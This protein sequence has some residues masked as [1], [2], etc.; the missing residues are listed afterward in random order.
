MRK[1]KNT[2]LNQIL[3]QAQ[4]LQG[5]L[6]RL[7]DDMKSKIVEASAGDGKVTAVVNGNRELIALSID[8]TVVSSEN[9]ELL[10]NLIISAVNTALANVREMVNHE[11]NKATGGFSIPGLM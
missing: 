4:R 7:E 3:S 1:A 6:G 9:P 8:P 10:E 2:G 5:K 11:M